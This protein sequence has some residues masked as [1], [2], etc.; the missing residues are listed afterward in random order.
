[1]CTGEWV[2]NHLMQ[3]ILNRTVSRKKN[4]DLSAHW[5][6]WLGDREGL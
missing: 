3:A 1:M 4:N 2:Y 5:H 6:C